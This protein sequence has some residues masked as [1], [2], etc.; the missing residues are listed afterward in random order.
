MHADACSHGQTG[1]I[2]ASESE[3]HDLHRRMKK[4]CVG[5]PCESVRSMSVQS[6]H[7]RHNHQ[8]SEDVNPDLV[9][10][11]KK[12]KGGCSSRAVHAVSRCFS[13]RRLNHQIAG[14]EEKK[15][16]KRMGVTIEFVL[17]TR[18]TYLPSWPPFCEPALRSIEA[19]SPLEPILSGHP[20]AS[21]LLKPAV[22]PLRL[23]PSLV[24]GSTSVWAL[25]LLPSL[26]GPYTCHLPTK[27]LVLS[28]SR[29]PRYPA[30]SSPP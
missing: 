12:K 11:V 26:G 14:G 3:G 30:T 29:Q 5:H 2:G 23:L 8:A 18:L 17:L 27:M 24:V 13:L 16:K 22:P 1:E 25:G 4:H 7:L 20:L 15:K 21:L 9:Q 28:P 10:H 6:P 19:F